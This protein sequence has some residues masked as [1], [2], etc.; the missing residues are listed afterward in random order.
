METGQTVFHITQHSAE[1][2]RKSIHIKKNAESRH[3][4]DLMSMFIE[5]WFSP[6]DRNSGFL[7]KTLDHQWVQKPNGTFFSI[8]DWNQR[9]W[10]TWEIFHMWKWNIVELRP[11]SVL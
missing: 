2:K 9:Y 5:E 11:P 1:H 3:S 7:E 4:T 6:L 8:I 10:E